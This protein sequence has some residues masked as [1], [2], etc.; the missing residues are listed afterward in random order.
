VDSISSSFERLIRDVDVLIDDPLGDSLARVVSS[1]TSLRKTLDTT[2]VLA[3][4]KHDIEMF[5]A[6]LD[7]FFRIFSAIGRRDMSGLA[8]LTQSDMAFIGAWGLPAHFLVLRRRS[9]AL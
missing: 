5:G 2:E 9:E 7:S 1:L 6:T 4:D 3:D 8:A